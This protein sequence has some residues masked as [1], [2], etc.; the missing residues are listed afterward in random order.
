M[1]LYC[2]S[3]PHGLP[4]S[5][6]LVLIILWSVSCIA[7]PAGYLAQ[8]H[9]LVWL[10]QLPMQHASGSLLQNPT[11]E[12]LTSPRMLMR[13]TLQ[14]QRVAV[15]EPVN[16]GVCGVLCLAQLLCR[17][18]WELSPTA[19]R[20]WSFHKNASTVHA[21][22]QLGLESLQPSRFLSASCDHIPS[23]C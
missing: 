16:A 5:L 10:P 19:H 2:T 9:P 21:W 11:S 23:L 13:Y 18:L 12:R 20:G 3:H 14:G 4:L 1:I 8:W 22:G 7:G 17:V 6:V 15:C